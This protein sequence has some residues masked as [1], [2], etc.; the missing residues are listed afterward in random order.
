M[1]FMGRWLT[2]QLDAELNFSNNQERAEAISN[3]KKGRL[4]A[5]S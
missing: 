4:S 3:Q 5:F 1:R 2:G